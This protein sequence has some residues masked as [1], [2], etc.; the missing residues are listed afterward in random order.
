MNTMMKSMTA[1]TLCAC[2]VALLGAASDLSA[3]TLSSRG[4]GQVLEF[5]YYTANAGQN[6]LVTLVNSTDRTKAVKARFRESYNGRVAVSFNIYLSP[7]DAWT[8]AVFA[9]DGV[10]GI[11][12]PDQSCL[13]PV[14]ILSGGFPIFYV[15][16]STAGFTGANADTG[17]SDISRLLEG[18]FEFFEMGEVSSD[19]HGFQTDIAHLNGT[20]HDCGAIINAWNGGVWAANGNTDMSP[21]TGGL[22]GSAAI[23]DV[24]NGTYFIVPPTVIDGFSTTAQH[25]APA[26][27]APDFDTASAVNGSVAAAVDVG[28]RLLQLHYASPVDAV[29][30]LLMSSQQMNEYEIDPDAGALSDWVSTFPTKRFYVDSR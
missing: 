26:S 17:P 27:D 18:H 4:I 6:T 10:V 5:P 25:T 29:S 23:V 12:T 7:H 1:K 13:A 2:L 15:P 14:P 16:F 22:Y 24:A 20:P 21:P 30:A 8:G 9:Q 19:A 11:A 28:G 3:M